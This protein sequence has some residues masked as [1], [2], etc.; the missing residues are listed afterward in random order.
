MAR[1]LK[2]AG[3]VFAAAVLAAFLAFQSGML[4]PG[5]EAVPI[6]GKPFAGERS[7]R[8][9]V[10]PQPLTG[11]ATQPIVHPF[12]A[13]E[14]GGLHGNAYNSDV[15]VTGGPLGPALQVATRSVS[16]FP[17][18]VCPTI[19][20][21]R[22]GLIVA[23]CA[24]FAGF[25]LNLFEPHTLK[26]LA[27]HR[28]VTRPSTFEALVKRNIDIIFLDTSGG[29]YFY[30]D[31]EDRA[32]LADADQR[33]QRIEHGQNAD[34]A[35]EFHV[36][37]SW[38]IKSQAP[39][40]CLDVY[41]WFPQGECDPITS[42]MP[43]YDGRIWWVTRFGRVGTVDP[44]T[45][46]IAAHRFAGEEIQNSLSA[47][48]DGM[49]VITDYALYHMVAGADGAPRTVWR[50][51]YL[52]SNQ[53]RYGNINNGS[54]S[55][56]T[57]MDDERGRKYV[58]IT[59]AGEDRTGLVVYRREANVEGPRQICRVPLFSAEASAVEISPIGWGR[60]IVA[61]NDAGY[62]SAFHGTSEAAIAGGI[63]RVDIREDD[64]GCDVV[65]A[66]PERV[67]AVVG[68]LSTNG[69]LY[70]Y[71]FEEQADG[72]NAWS[73]LA[74]DFATGK[75]VFQEFVGLGQSFDINWG[76]PAIARDGTV[77]LGI[78]EGIV[79]ISDARAGAPAE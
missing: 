41:N 20:F 69:L 23:M 32:V 12:M 65:W 70:F 71:T 31:N 49:Y 7:I 47:D 43:D 66:A 27:T 21:D 18:G 51:Q 1:L 58:A 10:T 62:R 35:W 52:R 36:T 4:R 5:E 39:H 72:E 74:L 2:L 57:L 60:S 3:G 61:K 76:S 30:L 15:H 19:T 67:P 16:P 75:R 73:F 63:V 28:L 54:G 6:A 25:E 22:N 45:G 53:Y 34:G 44:E 79:A 11:F 50:E 26:L 56:P 37:D 13:F 59:D 64:S 8:S 17:G 40:D 33:I 55:T 46:Q 42:V 24:S 14:G 29:S 38:D 9:G 78:L 68:K 48:A 77:Y